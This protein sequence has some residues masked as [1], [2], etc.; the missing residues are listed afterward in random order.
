MILELDVIDPTVSCEG[1]GECCHNQRLP[2]F[3]FETDRVPPELLAEC[4]AELDRWKG[5][6]QGPCIWLDLATKA[7]RHYEHRPDI[8]HDFSVGGESCLEQRR[9]AGA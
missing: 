5:E 3:V 1:C 6:S 9:N 4:V 2:P 7:C 8:C